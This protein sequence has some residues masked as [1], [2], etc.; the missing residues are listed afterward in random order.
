MDEPTAGLDPKGRD[1]ILELVSR[2]HKEKGMGIL[3]VS[4]S[5]EDVAK[6]ASRIVVMNQGMVAMDDAP[7]GVFEKYKEL[8][9]M[10]LAAPQICYLMNELKEKGFPVDEGVINLEAAKQSILACVKY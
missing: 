1:Q 3:L 10:G 5:M 4:H 9:A 7:A 2:L 6:Y 8:E